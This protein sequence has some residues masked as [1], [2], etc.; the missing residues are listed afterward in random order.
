MQLLRLCGGMVLP[1]AEV[2]TTDGRGRKTL[3]LRKNWTTDG[4]A[5]R[6]TL[7]RCMFEASVPILT[8]DPSFRPMGRNWAQRLGD[9]EW[10]LRAQ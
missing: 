10:R 5:A 9:L 7:D 6:A 2:L 4:F 8:P 1:A 3:D